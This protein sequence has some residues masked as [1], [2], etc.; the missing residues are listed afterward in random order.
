MNEIAAFVWEKL[1]TSVSREELLAAILDE[2][3][4][5]SVTAA[6]DLDERLARLKERDIIIDD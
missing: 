6:K 5:D 2:Y 4:T 3:E 1:Q